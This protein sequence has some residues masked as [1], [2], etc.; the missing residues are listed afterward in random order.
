MLAIYPY[1]SG[2]P[3]FFK[4]KFDEPYMMYRDWRDLTTILLCTKGEMDPSKLPNSKMKR[5]ETKV[6]VKWVID[7][8]K[9]DRA[10]FSEFNG[11]KGVIAIREKFLEFLKTEQGMKELASVKDGNEKDALEVATDK[12][13]RTI[14][15]P[16]GV[17][18]CGAY[19]FFFFRTFLR[20]HIFL[21]HR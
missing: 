7:E 17:P 21:Q 8:I 3:F 9:K 20:S 1:K 12:L 6:Y 19:F 13:N 4:I 15:L 14:I 10:P 5:P 16:V 18:G 2:A 11:G